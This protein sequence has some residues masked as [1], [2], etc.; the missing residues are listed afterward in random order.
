M[1]RRILLRLSEHFFA[2]RGETV[3]WALCHAIP[4]PVSARGLTVY[5]S[6]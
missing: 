3:E 5:V 6:W 2:E 4:F 1:R